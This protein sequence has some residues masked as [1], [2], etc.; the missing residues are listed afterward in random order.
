[1]LQGQPAGNGPEPEAAEE[2][3]DGAGSSASAEARADAVVKRVYAA[4]GLIGVYL[5]WTICAWFIFTYGMLIYTTLGDSAQQEFAK[6]WG[7]VAWHPERGAT[8]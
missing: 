3:E 7:H 1:M 5:C 2:D 4:A 6:T 8:P